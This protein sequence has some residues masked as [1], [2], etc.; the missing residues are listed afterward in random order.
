MSKCPICGGRV[1]A[2]KTMFS[3]DTGDGVVVVRNA[4]A[5]VCSQCGEDWLTDKA[6]ARVEEVLTRARR[7]KTQIEV[8]ALAGT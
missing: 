6:A 4:P 5:R 2:G 8:V 3:T 7:E 1:K